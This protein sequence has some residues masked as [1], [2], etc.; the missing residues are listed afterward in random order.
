MVAPL[1]IAAA[2]S[3]LPL[4]LKLAPELAKWAGGPKAE[5]IAVHGA[6][7]I[8]SITGT[9]DPQAAEIILNDPQKSVDAR[10]AL[11][12]IAA[13]QQAAEQQAKLDTLRAELS[14]VAS[15]RSQTVALAQADSKIAW[16]APIIS[17]VIVVGFFGAPALYAWALR[18]PDQIWLGALIAGFGAVVQFWIGASRSGQ[19]AQQA[20]ERVAQNTADA[21]HKA[22]AVAV[23]RAAV[24]AATEAA[25]PPQTPQVVLIPPIP[26]SIQAPPSEAVGVEWKQG[27][28]GGARWRL[29]PEGVHVEG[30]A[31]V[32]RTVGEPVTVRKAWSLYGEMMKAECLKRGV[33]VEI[34]MAIL[35]TESGRNLNPSATLVEPDQRVSSGIM[36]V[37]TATASQML[38]RKVD[39]NELKNPM[40]SIAAGVA[41]LQHQKDK[42][43]F[44]PI[45]SAASYNAGGLYQARPQDNNRFNLRSTGDHLERM[46]RWYGDV[47]FVAK[48]DGWFKDASQ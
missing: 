36:Q 40:T 33:P 12:K 15:A 45:L 22:A 28:Y 39:V 23:E 37:L 38:G 8:K 24:V 10:I 29:L 13:E 16:A 34:G 43:W 4:V 17:V 6:E 20:V 44:D 25:K 47:C 35:C 3:L 19:Q 5:D 7:I 9:T 1:V 31:G 14:D 41:Y 18:E 48:A 46:I 26:A 32:A 21:A 11:A 2:T 30:D 27:P 42:T